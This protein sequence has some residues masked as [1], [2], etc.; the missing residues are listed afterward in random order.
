M[1]L[2]VYHVKKVSSS[3]SNFVK[4]RLLLL[5]KP[6]PLK[7]SHRKNIESLVSTLLD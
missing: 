6:T 2:K 3:L 5:S 7:I 1:Y 4:K